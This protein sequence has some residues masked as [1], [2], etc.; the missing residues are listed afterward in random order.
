MLG[1]VSFTLQISPW[2]RFYIQKIW[3]MTKGIEK[4]TPNTYTSSVVKVGTQ[5]IMKTSWLE[6]IFD[7]VIAYW[8]RDKKPPRRHKIK[9][10]EHE[11]HEIKPSENI[12][13]CHRGLLRSFWHWLWESDSS[14]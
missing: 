7:L 1:F 2:M 12:E 8:L 3:P 6:I 9:V 4:L 14:F 13:K 10:S 5:N 11:I